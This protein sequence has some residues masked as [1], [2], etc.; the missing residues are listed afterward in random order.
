MDAKLEDIKAR[1]AASDGKYSR[2]MG[3]DAQKHFHSCAW[4]DMAYL[5]KVIAGEVDAGKDSSDAQADSAP[6]QD[7]SEKAPE[8]VASDAEAEKRRAERRAKR[9]A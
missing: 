3:T 2:I 1:H 8:A 6:K 7:G 5:L 9:E 4:D